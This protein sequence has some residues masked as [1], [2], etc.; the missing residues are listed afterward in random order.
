MM[1]S[2]LTCL[3]VLFMLMTVA[4]W[5]QRSANAGGEDEAVLQMRKV[6]RAWTGKTLRVTSNNRNA[7][8]RDFAKAF[9]SQYKGYKPNACMME[10]LKNPGGNSYEEKPYL[11]DDAPRNGY[12]KCDMRWQCEYMTEICYWRRPN[13]HSLVGVLMQKGFESG[14]N[15]YLLMFYDFDPS[16]NV[17]TPDMSA[18]NSVNRQIN[19][20]H[21]GS[22]V[23]H[24]PKEGKN[25]SVMCFNYNVDEG[26]DPDADMFEVKWTGNGF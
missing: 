12:I 20:H 13:G 10:Y 26:E 17:M 25:I 5:G 23:V 14:R 4:A 18:L 7:R 2:K 19:R 24:L 15:E 16:T 6:E 1:R 8:I 9:C 21:T 22:P 3:A 11:V